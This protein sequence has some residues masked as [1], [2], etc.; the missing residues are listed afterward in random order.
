MT[1]INDGCTAYPSNPTVP[2]ERKVR[3]LVLE[4]E[5]IEPDFTNTI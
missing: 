5:T 3:C 2:H 1:R 4:K